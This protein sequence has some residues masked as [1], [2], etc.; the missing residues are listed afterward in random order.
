VA[1]TSNSWGQPRKNAPP[2]ET[3][4]QTVSPQGTEQSPFV[5]KV[6]P[7]KPPAEAEADQ[8]QKESK[9]Q[10][11]LWLEI[12]TAALVGV[13]LLQLAAFSWQGVQLR[14]TVQASEKTVKAAEDE[15]KATHRPKIRVKHVW[16]TSDLWQG[17]KITVNVWY[18]NNGT[19]NAV[20]HETGVRFV[21][22]RNDR[23]IP[24]NPRITGLNF[25]LPNREI[26]CGRN[27]ELQGLTDGTVLTPEQNVEI[28]QGKSRLYCIGYVAYSDKAGR[29]R[30]TGFCRVLRF[31]KGS[32]LAHKDNGR[33]R[34]YPDRDYKYED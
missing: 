22:V 15:F 18:V 28:Q 33:F 31:L 11:D 13:G 7:S 26:E 27:W 4:Q 19:S 6:L 25:D 17:E 12:W 30:I 10:S 2:A 8:K 20:F 21:V 16:L 29:L 5:V 1:P 24:F 14:K 23:S 32:I 34:K 3:N 9:D